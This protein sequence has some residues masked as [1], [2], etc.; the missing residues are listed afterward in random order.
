MDKNKEVKGVEGKTESKLLGRTKF[1]IV[2]CFLILII[3][4]MGVIA[5]EMMQ[6]TKHS[7]RK[8]IEQR[9]VNVGSKYVYD[10]R[11]SPYSEILS[12]YKEANDRTDNLGVPLKLLIEQSMKDSSVS[13]AE[14]Y[15]IQHA[16]A[17]LHSDD[18][19]ARLLAVAQKNSSA[20]AAS[21][22][23]GNEEPPIK[24]AA[25]AYREYISGFAKEANNGIH[26][27]FDNDGTASKLIDR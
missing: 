21:N 26:E 22:L 23:S 3:S 13:D 18:A 15:E 8:R 6:S 9:E 1:L 14:F 20:Q 2:S 12:H 25:L 5:F 10:K 4:G 16:Y 19:K 17:K 27:T 11:K 24:K 7:D